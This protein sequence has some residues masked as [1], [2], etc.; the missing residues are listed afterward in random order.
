MEKLALPTRMKEWELF[1]KSHPNSQN[2]RQSIL[3]RTWDHV[4]QWFG[5]KSIHDVAAPKEGNATTLSFKEVPVTQAVSD[6]IQVP[7]DIIES[8][9]DELKIFERDLGYLSQDIDL[10]SLAKTIGTNHS[11]LSR[12]VNHVKGKPF[13]KYLNDMRIEFAYVDLQTDP[14]KRRYTIEAI[15]FENGFRSA[16]SFSKKFKQRYDV[17]PS[18]FLRKLNALEHAS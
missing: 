8:I 4:F 17:Y 3:S 2:E 10:P 6:R 16:E 1:S 11:Y 14:K 12:V 9:L 7:Q 15:A 18:E 13:K 5:G